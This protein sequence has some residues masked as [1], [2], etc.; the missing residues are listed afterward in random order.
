MK[1]LSPGFAN[2]VTLLNGGHYHDGTTLGDKLKITRSAV[3]KSIKKLETYGVKLTSIKGKGYALLE[4]LLLL[5]PKIIKQGIACKNIDINIFET[6]DST[7]EYQKLFIGHKNIKI[8]MAEQQTHGKGRLNRKWHSPFAQNIY[9]SC[10]YPFQKDISELAGLS[11]VVSLAVVKTLACYGLPKA[12]LIKWPNDII[13][14]HKKL[15][16]IL[17]EIQAESHGACHAIMGIGINVN[18]LHAENHFI[19]QTWTSLRKIMATYIDR[20]QLCILLIDNLIT[21][22]KLFEKQRLSSF[23]DEWNTIDFLKHKK[24]SLKHGHKKIYGKAM[25]ID[26]L[27]HLILQTVDGSSQS[28]SSGDTTIMK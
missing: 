27:G 24:I 15:A 9:L 10:S 7:N 17:I 1:K 19:A 3:W 8:C 6:I 20:N 4:P 5:N 21:Y 23:I 28:F 2:L 26:S 13:Y 14:D 16:G 25:G 12:L 22:L 11:L 18:M